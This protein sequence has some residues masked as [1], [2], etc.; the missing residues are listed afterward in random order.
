[1][2]AKN[3]EENSFWHCGKVKAITSKALMSHKKVSEL[4]NSETEV[5]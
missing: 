2:K 4:S 1:M 5:E 3:F